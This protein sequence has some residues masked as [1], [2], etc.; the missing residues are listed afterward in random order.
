MNKNHLLGFLIGLCLLSVNV[1]EAADESVELHWLQEE[2]TK[3]EIG[4]SWGTPWPEGTIQEEQEFILKN[5]N[6]ELLPIQSWVMA[7]WP[8]GSIKWSG[9]ATLANLKANKLNLI[10][11]SQ[12]NQ[13]KN[14]NKILLNEE[15]S[16]YIVNTGKIK[17]RIPRSGN[18]LIDYIKI[19]GKIVAEKGQ[20]VCVEQ[21]KPYGSL[22]TSVEQ[23]KFTGEINK[24]TIEQKGPVRAV[25]KI[26]GLHSS[27]S[28]DKKWLPFK[29]RLYFY[30]GKKSIRMVHTMIYDGEQ[31]KDFITGLGLH[32]NI[33][34]REEAHNRHIRFAGENGGLWQEPVKPLIGRRRIRYEK[35]NIYQEQV[36]GKRVPD[37]KE[38]DK[39]GQ[40]LISEWAAW[41][42][43]RLY[44]NS[45]DGFLIKK[46]TNEQSRWIDAGSGRR[47]S[48]LAFVGDV[49]SGL[50]VGVKDFW[51]SYPS[52]LEINNA[53]KKEA[54]LKVWLWPP[55]ASPMDLRHY[56]T[57]AHSLEASYE[58]VQEGLATPNGI[59]R[60][61]ELMLYP[62]SNVPS[63]S[64]LVKKTMISRQ[65]PQLVCSPQYYHQTKAFGEWSLPHNTTP[66]GQW[67]EGKLADALAFY[68]K[69][70]EQR[71]WYGFWDYGDVMHAYDPVRHNWRY[72]IGGFA[73]A[74][75]EL[76]PDIW[77]WYS[78]L[79][80]GREDVFK[81]AE[82][83]TRHCG[84]VDVYH[85][86]KLKGLGSRHN[87]S[88]W[89]CGAKEVRISQAFPKRFYY[90][91]STDERTGDLMREVVRADTT[92][93]NWDPLRKY[94][95]EI[96][97][98]T[99]IRFGPDWLALAGNWMTEWERTGNEKWKNKILTGV[100]SFAK[101]P[102]GL[103]SGES[104]VFGYDPATNKVYNLGEEKI[105]YAH[106]SVL[107][108][109]PEVAFELTPL[110]DNEKW[111]KIWLQYCELFSASARKVKKTFGRKAEIGRAAPHYARMPA[112][113]A[114]IKNDKQ[115]AKK[116]WDQ[117]L[118]P[119]YRKSKYLFQTRTVKPPDVLEKL[120]EIPFVSTNNTAQWSLNA[121]EMLEMI[122]ENLPEE[123]PEELKMKEGD[124]NLWE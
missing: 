68:K 14:F 2:A 110:L 13:P 105:G 51:Q 56:D 123:V 86:G 35:R 29:I 87:V 36:A 124:N 53:R 107:Q 34:M 6:G 61:S 67:I 64:N 108:G 74:N 40:Y 81:M 28:V 119:R 92:M 98:P 17:C 80:T 43:Y 21:D 54:Q 11:Q 57:T 15:K 10:P 22:G 106:L 79:R 117:F 113:A 111:D 39:Q 114:K 27:E 109:G 90:Y 72:D 60:T 100:N 19:D 46:R 42:D 93:A 102:Y 12:T 45:A 30:S 104:G 85:M 77:L 38:F 116:A 16:G 20:L 18:V 103:F 44:Q 50:A 9:H 71:N 7:Y 3:G 75:T 73:W 37:K 91:I 26:E 5:D 48:G 69:E 82:A 24:V 99:H 52:A 58:D 23:I 1:L 115:L 47:S 83:M 84:E 55:E 49:S 122:G 41:N 118:F 25:I 62:E 76:M 59:A 96:D 70:I 63:D 78:F 121:I 32:F 112:Y 8:D 120:E 89:G 88:H 33:P 101:M 95:P 97:Y 65:T 31:K 4:V 94:E 66:L